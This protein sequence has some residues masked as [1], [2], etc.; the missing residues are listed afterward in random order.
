MS[1]TKKLAKSLLS[2]F[3]AVGIMAI[4]P[5]TASAVDFTITTLDDSVA[6]NQNIIFE[7]NNIG[8]GFKSQTYPIRVKNES[9]SPAKISLVSIAPDSG[10]ANTLLPGVK[11]FFS[12]PDGTNSISDT[13]DKVIDMAFST[14]CIMPNT[15]VDAFYTGFSFGSNL[16]NEYQGTSFKLIYSFL[17]STSETDCAEVSPEPPNPPNPPDTG[18]LS[19][20]KSGDAVFSS[21]TI[22]IIVSFVS[23]I[24][25]LLLVL[26]RRKKS[27]DDKS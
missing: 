26:K 22:V 3:C 23:T 6:K 15:E 9:S 2:A 21:L 19:V 14:D 25:F 18:G 24:I 7:E 17:V 1:S 12:N 20:L 13:Y 11:I 27:D 8:P 5:A 4:V 10:N 16:G